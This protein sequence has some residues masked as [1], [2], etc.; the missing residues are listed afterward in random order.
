MIKALIRLWFRLKGIWTSIRSV[1]R[2]QWW[3]K[4]DRECEWV[5]PYGFVPEAGC[6]VH[7]PPP[8]R[9]GERGESDGMVWH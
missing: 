5:A 6:P 1:W 3:H 9:P 4:C 2:S 8:F 7:D